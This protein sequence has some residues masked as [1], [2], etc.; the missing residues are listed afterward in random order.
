MDERSI[1]ELA[2]IY[3]RAEGLSS[4]RVGHLS[5]AD[6]KF[7]ARLKAGRSCTLRTAN[8]VIQWFSDNWPDSVTWPAGVDRPAP[9]GGVPPLPEVAGLSWEESV[10]AL[11]A[12]Y[13]GAGPLDRGPLYDALVRRAGVLNA[14]GK[15]RSPRL[16]R[17]AIACNRETWEY[18]VANY[19]AGRRK[20]GQVPRRGGQAA[21]LLDAL[22]LCGDVRFQ[23]L[24]APALDGEAA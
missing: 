19:A 8:A 12:A 3:R 1:I 20:C 24:R 7:F 21:K 4:A 9:S 14:D 17:F 5:A 11:R 18:V 15:V 23:H 2:E 10:R 6:G 16:L 13:I 22:A